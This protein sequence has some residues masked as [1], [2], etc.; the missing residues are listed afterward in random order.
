M[1]LRGNQE[2]ITMCRKGGGGVKIKIL[3]KQ[4][5]KS[6]HHQNKGDVNCGWWAS[7]KR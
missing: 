2:K 4:K 5:K 6:P 7:N 1:V 3:K